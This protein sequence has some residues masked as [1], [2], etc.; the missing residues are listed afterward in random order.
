MLRKEVRGPASGKTV[1]ATGFLNLNTFVWQKM[2]PV[3]SD[4]EFQSLSFIWKWGCTLFCFC[5]AQLV[6]VLVKQ[7]R[8]LDWMTSML[9]WINFAGSRILLSH[10][11]LYLNKIHISWGPEEILNYLMRVFPLKSIQENASTRRQRQRLPTKTCLVW[12]WSIQV[13]KRAHGRLK[14]LASVRRSKVARRKK[15]TLIAARRYMWWKNWYVMQC[16][17]VGW[18]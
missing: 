4:W 12:V 15:I 11:L 9:L 5:G 3:Y 18:D 2:A 16:W 17:D 10:S 6:D 14:L 8:R 7:G 1:R 13:S